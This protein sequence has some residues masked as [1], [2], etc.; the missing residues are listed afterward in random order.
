V[1]GPY[2][3]DGTTPT[4]AFEYHPEA[5]VPWALTRHLDRFRDAADP[6]EA[7]VFVDGLNRV[8]QTKRDA[9]IHVAPDEPAADVMVVS[10]R[11]RFD[12]FGR[13]VEQSYPTTEPLGRAGTFN[14]A[15]DGIEP[16]RTQYD[17]LDRV[18]RTAFPDGTH[19]TVEYGFGADRTGDEQFAQTAT[20]ANGVRTRTYRNLRQ[21]VTGTQRCH[22]TADGTT[23]RSIR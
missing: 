19:S 1:T 8:V 15:V 5:T 6:I 7:A 3:Q 18:T 16:T 11:V 9:A 12:A 21:L 4:V 13:A 2:E 14:A 17:V 22:K 10:G 20:D 23:T